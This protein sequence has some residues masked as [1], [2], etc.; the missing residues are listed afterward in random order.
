MGDNGSITEFFYN[1]VPGGIFIPLL[2]FFDKDL[3]TIFY[4]KPE[5]PDSA[6]IIFVYII[7]GFLFGFIFQGFTKI[8]RSKLYWNESVAKA[9]IKRNEEF[10]PMEEI[11]ESVSKKELK[12]NE[13]QLI[14]F[15]DNYL[16]AENPAFMPTHFSSR[17]AFW[18]NTGFALLSLIVLSLLHLIQTNTVQ[19]F[20]LIISMFI[21]FHI[22][23]I[24]FCGFYD[25][26]LKSYYMKVV[27][28]N[29][30]KK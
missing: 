8:V 10:I 14:Y 9:V 20:L 12:N 6:T 7:F 21:S 15:M 4:K 27:W 13:L 2:K 1:V 3:I 26:I 28:V 5:N 22:A 18:A 23:N 24:Y 17:F 16:R 29:L 25:S 19:I 30:T 11:Y